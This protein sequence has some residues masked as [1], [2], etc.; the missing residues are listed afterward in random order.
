MGEELGFSRRMTLTDEAA[1]VR[2]AEDLAIALRPGDVV[3]L[4]GDLGAGK[5]TLARAM[6]RAMADDAGLEVPSPTFTLVQGYQLPRFPVAHV[7]LYRLGAPE[8]VD[9]LGLDE[10]VA[11]GAVLIEW[12]ER[13]EGS[14]PRGR[15][16]ELSLTQG[17]DGN[18]SREATIATADAAAGTRLRRS[19]LVRDFLDEAGLAGARRRYLQGDAST[20]AYERIGSG[21]GRRV[22]MNHP[23]EPDDETGRARLAYYRGARLAEDTR[24]FVAIGRALH[25]RGFSTP[26]ILAADTARGL[27]LLEDLG[28]EFCV[29]GD[30]P[31]PMVERYQ[32]AI[33]VLV[34][35]HAQALPSEIDDGAGG[36]YRLP[37]FDATIFRNEVMVLTDWG[38]GHLTGRELGGDEK[39]AFLALWAP[40]F[41]EVTSGPLTWSLRDFHSPNLMWLAERQGFR[42]LGI[43]DHQ[44]AILSHP[45]YDV[46]SL[47]QDARVTVPAA[48]ETALVERYVAGRRAHDGGFDEAGFR[49]GYAILGA[50]RNTRL[51][52]LWARLLRRDGKSGYLRHYPRTSDYLDRCLA[53]EALAPLADWFGRMLPGEVRRRG[54]EINPPRSTG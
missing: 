11:T 50:Q 41:A 30:P 19:L 22:L 32:T 42:R 29:A 6:L 20:R 21:D 25:E 4:H 17:A 31:A 1:T 45:A 34:E 38:F 39:A 52:G 28:D 48:L 12:P 26:D 36:R 43:I 33:D 8:E 54:V 46:A 9:E 35:L 14:L 23:P 15:T 5:S 27:I 37:A 53:Q 2:L 18:D 49:R 40:L 51:L 3:L 10:A 7:D 16:I 13:G 44:D 24:P 47:A